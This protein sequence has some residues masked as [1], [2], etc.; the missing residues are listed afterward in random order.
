MKNVYYSGKDGRR[1]SVAEKQTSDTGKESVAENQ[2]KRNN[3]F[4]YGISTAVGET[5]AYCKDKVMNIIK[6]DMKITDGVSIERAHRVGKAIIC[7]LLSCKDEDKVRKGAKNLAS[8]NN[9]ISVREDL[10]Q[11][12]QTKRI[13]QEWAFLNY[14]R[15]FFCDIK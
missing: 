12:V 8:T 7:K 13:V 3:L 15:T 6:T 2:S 14:S 4:F 9:D 11:S 10:S 1:K 5:W